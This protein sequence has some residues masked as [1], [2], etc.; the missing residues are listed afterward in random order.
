M[1]NSLFRRKLK[2]VLA[3]TA[4]MVGFILLFRILY[5]VY[6]GTLV[7]QFFPELNRN[8]YTFLVA[9]LLAIAVP[10]HLFAVSLFMQ[11]EMFSYIV[12]RISWIAVIISGLWLGAAL[13]ARLYII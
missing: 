1:N 9:L 4:L 3:I 13:I 10:F 11:R 5:Q 2:R 12:N 8:G 6:T 7:E